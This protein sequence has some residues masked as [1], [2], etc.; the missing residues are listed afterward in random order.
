MVMAKKEI[1]Y[2]PPFA[3]GCYSCNTVFIDRRSNN[4]RKDLYKVVD[5]IKKDQVENIFLECKIKKLIFPEETRNDTTTLLPFKK[6][7]FHVAYQA[8]LLIQPI[9][10]SKY[11]FINRDNNNIQLG[12]D[13][14]TLL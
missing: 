6:G 3:L 13:T 1:F 2:N 8:C 12:L 11:E 14:I 7:A 9:V 10:V 4:N 5:V